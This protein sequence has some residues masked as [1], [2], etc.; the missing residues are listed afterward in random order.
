MNVFFSLF[1]SLSSVSRSILNVFSS[2]SFFFLYVSSCVPNDNEFRVCFCFT[3]WIYCKHVPTRQHKKKN[4]IYK[5]KGQTVLE[6]RSHFRAFIQKHTKREWMYFFFFL[7]SIVNRF[8]C[9]VVFFSHLAIV[10]VHTKENGKSKNKTVFISFIS[11]FKMDL[12]F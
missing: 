2:R 1:L 10:F 9:S 3:S 8:A 6:T 11:T 7:L 5:R 12:H 4:H